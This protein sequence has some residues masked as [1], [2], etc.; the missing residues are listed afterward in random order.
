MLST[1]QRFATTCRR[2]AHHLWRNNPRTKHKRA[3]T[4]GLWWVAITCHPTP[5]TRVRI[6]R[7]LKTSDL[8]VAIQRRDAL[9]RDLSAG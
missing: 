7:S 2:R 6:R 9:L 8:E 1:V 5:L 3:A 4:R